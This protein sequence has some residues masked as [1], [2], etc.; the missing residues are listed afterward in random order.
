MEARSTPAGAPVLEIRDLRLTMPTFEGDAKVLKGIDLELARGDVLGL[1]G[2]TG[3][4]KS[5]TALAALRL[6][7]SPPAQIT[8]KRVAFEGKDLLRMPSRE[9]RAL[10]ASSVAIVFQDP[11]TNLNP[12]LG[13]GSQMIDA[14]LCRRGYGSNLSLS[15]LGNYLP[16][17]R[18]RRKEA[19]EVAIEMLGRVG[20]AHPARVMGAYP[21]ELSGGMRQRVLIA[22]A[23]GGNPELLV[24][25]EATTALDVS[26]Q[27]Q[28]LELVRELVSQMHLSVLWITHNL[29][30]VAHL[31][32]KV[33]VMYAGVIVEYAPTDILFRSPAHPYTISLMKAVPTRGKRGQ[34]L[35]STPG[36]L[37]SL[38]NPPLG[39][40]FHPRCTEASVRCQEQEP[41]MMQISPGHLVRCHIRTAA[42]ASGE[43]QQEC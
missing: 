1:V 21:H 5:M 13:V 26:I 3:C 24:A 28:I 19:A 8:A 30:V 22:M 27:A 40:L 42:S 2:E 4:G 20:I 16:A 15:P 35:E 18:A 41:P 12:V 9:L 37:P 33:V 25:D 14:I 17:S 6:V 10:R 34:K 31:C 29:G 39:C 43:V 36:F 11:D 32:E 7:E 23:L 38:L